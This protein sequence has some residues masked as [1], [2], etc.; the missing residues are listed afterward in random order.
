MEARK[1]T[2]ETEPE[3]EDAATTPYVLGTNIKCVDEVTAG[4]IAGLLS[5][6]VDE[7]GEEETQ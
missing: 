6:T 2:S 7:D 3:H 1:R 5:A 4:K